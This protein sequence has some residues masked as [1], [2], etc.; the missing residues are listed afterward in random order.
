MRKTSDFA[1]EAS[2]REL[3][4][5]L[6]I[7]CVYILG[8]EVVIRLNVEESDRP[9]SESCT[10]LLLDKLQGI[11]SGDHPVLTTLSLNKVIGQL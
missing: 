7:S 2:G 11:G 10:R 6:A 3:Q 5:R 1:W 4:S 9:L 8:I